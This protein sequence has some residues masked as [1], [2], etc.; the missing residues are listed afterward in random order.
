M[1]IFLIGKDG[2]IGR[3]LEKQ[4]IKLG[5]KIDAYGHNDLDITQRELLKE[6]ISYS[7]P[8]VV[9]NTAAY[10]V[11]PEC[12]KFPEIAFHVNAAAVKDIADVCKA[13]NAKF[14]HFSTDKVFDG[15]SNDPYKEDDRPNPVQIYGISKLASEY[16]AL[17]YNP[18]TIIIRTNGVY[19]GM[20]GSKSKGGNFV[21]YILN[22]A[23]EKKEIEI[24]SDQKANL[25]YAADLAEGTLKLLAKDAPVDIYHLINEGYASWADFAQEIVERAHLNMKIIPV[26]RKGYFNGV[27]IPQ[28]N[29]MDNKKAKSLGVVLPDWKDALARYITLLKKKHE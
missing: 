24:S 9:I 12:E 29:V 14:V 11:V 2:Q 17:S 26:D 16:I 19:G 25:A 15:F 22:Q 7:A 23:K 28:F 3:E 20:S 4:A 8:D 10:H 6:K 27:R 18:N 5:H 1:K 21:L 13:V